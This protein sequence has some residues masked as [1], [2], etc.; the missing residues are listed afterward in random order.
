MLAPPVAPA[1]LR[2][3]VVPVAGVAPPVS[4]RRTVRL[5][6]VPLK[7]AAGRKRRLSAAFTTRA[8]ARLGEP[9]ALQVPPVKYCQVPWATVTASAMMAT[10]YSVLYDE[11]PL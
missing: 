8:E 9:T 2:S 7:S 6:G 4:M 1:L 10:P 5:P 3:T 11:P